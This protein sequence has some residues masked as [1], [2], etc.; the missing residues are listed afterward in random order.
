MA[1][2][3]LVTQRSCVSQKLFLFRAE[4]SDVAQPSCILHEFSSSQRWSENNLHL[5][6]EMIEMTVFLLPEKKKT[7]KK[8]FF[9]SNAPLLSK[10]LLSAKEQCLIFFNLLQGVG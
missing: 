6:T 2:F 4:L 8:I 1:S 9:Q 10:E 5:N 3:L 7:K